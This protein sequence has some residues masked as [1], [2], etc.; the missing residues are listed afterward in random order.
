MVGLVI[1]LLN[2][3][4]LPFGLWVCY[5]VS[6]WLHRFCRTGIREVDQRPRR[7]TRCCLAAFSPA[8]CCGCCETTQISGLATNHGSDC[9]R[10][11]VD[12][13]RR[14]SGDRRVRC[15]E[16]AVFRRDPAAPC[17]IAIRRWRSQ[18]LKPGNPDGGS[19][20]QT[21][22][23]RQS[24]VSRASDSR[25]NNP[26]SAALE[27]RVERGGPIIA[28]RVAVRAEVQ[29]RDGAALCL[30]EGCGLTQHG[31]LRCGATA[32]GLRTQFRQHVGVR[33]DRHDA[34][35]GGAGGQRERK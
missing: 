35:T 28:T 13:A 20:P 6:P 2:A 15:P 34:G 18:T 31:L 11:R 21:S 7:S 23:F 1:L 17:K 32:P 19:S 10:S 27:R 24:R 5:M 26:R 9:R 8:Y 22:A 16:R 29:Q 25:C 14:L 3:S 4:L 33:P 12:P 30:A